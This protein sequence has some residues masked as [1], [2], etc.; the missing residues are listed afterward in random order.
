MDK[1]EVAS[2]ST[3]ARDKLP[4]SSSRVCVR[5]RGCCDD[6]RS[7]ASEF[8]GY[9]GDALNIFVSVFWGE[10]EFR[11]ELGADGFSEEQGDTSAALLIQ[12]DL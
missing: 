7:R 12:Y 3:S 2:R 6:G 10:S 5:C 9:E 11:G 8:G 4:C 1:E